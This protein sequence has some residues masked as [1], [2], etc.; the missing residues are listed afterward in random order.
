MA[1]TEIGKKSFNFPVSLEKQI[2]LGSI[3]VLSR[4]KAAVFSH[5]NG[6]Q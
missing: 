1:L 5:K 3:P 6:H 2:L 4:L